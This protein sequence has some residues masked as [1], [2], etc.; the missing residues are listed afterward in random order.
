MQSTEKTD[1]TRSAVTPEMEDLLALL[2]WVPKDAHAD[3]RAAATALAAER[4]RADWA[5]AALEG[6][7]DEGAAWGWNSSGVAYADNP[8]R[9]EAT[10]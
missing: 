5:E 10:A 2:E 7:W 3:I 8:Y 4:D 9:S 6:A 1:E